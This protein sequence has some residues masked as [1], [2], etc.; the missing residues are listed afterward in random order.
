MNVAI[1][2]RV[3]IAAAVAFAADKA[4]AEAL[5]PRALLEGVV[6]VREQIP[7]SYLHIRY[8]FESRLIRRE[9]EYVVLFDGALRYFARTN[10][11]ERSR[12]LFDGKDV[13]LL[14]GDDSV[15]V[16]DLHTQ[17]SDLLFDPCAL[18]ITSYSWHITPRVAM[19]VD[20]AKISLVGE[21]RINGRVCQHVRAE[22]PEWTVDAWIDPSADFGVYQH[23]TNSRGGRTTMRSVYENTAYPWLPSRVEQDSYRPDGSFMGRKIVDVLE[24]RKAGRIS[25]ETWTLGGLLQGLTLLTWVPVTDVRKGECIGFWRDGR[26]G[27][28]FPWEPAPAPPPMSFRRVA[29][30]VV[31]A[32]LVAGPLVFFWLRRPPASPGPGDAL[33]S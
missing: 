14:G 9:S 29:I 20:A 21:E 31:L 19:S 22:N 30:L 4:S 15:I 6:S 16:R 11:N 13:M 23:E 7:P 12:A 10:S 28:P 3:W 33:P 2:F 17:T 32:A 25:M 27:P 8:T 5:N 24:A 18:G 1:P 26:L